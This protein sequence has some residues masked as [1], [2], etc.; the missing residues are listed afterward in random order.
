MNGWQRFA[1]LI[2]CCFVVMVLYPYFD[3]SGWTFMGVAFAMWTGVIMV[4]SVI[5]NLFGLYKFESLNKLIFF[6]LICAIMYSLLWYFPQEDKVTPINKIKYGEIPTK[7]DMDGVGLSNYKVVKPGQIAYVPDTSRRGDKISLGFND[8]KETFLVSS[9]STVFG[10]KRKFL[11]PEHLMLFLTRK[12]N[13]EEKSWHFTTFPLEDKGVVEGFLCIENSRRHPTSAALFSTLIPY[14]LHE[15]SRFA[16]EDK[17]V[18]TVEQLMG[19]PDLRSYMNTIYSLNSDKYSTLGAIC[20]DIPSMP[21][22]NNSQGFEY[23]SKLLWY[24]S[25][26]LTD[27]FGPAL[28]FR[29][30]EAEFIAFCPNTTKDVFSGKCM[31]AVSNLQR[32]Y[33]QDVRIGSSWADGTFSGR[34]LVD[35]ARENM[36][37]E[38]VGPY[39]TTA[40]IKAMEGLFTDVEKLNFPSLSSTISRR[41]I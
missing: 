15:R 6:V 5:S 40:G 24:V 21:A 26:T 14:M 27:I 10:T 38:K 31:R 41:S 19:L 39:P 35:E 11:L 18:K 33:P 25:K 22:I 12:E 30:W 8:T 17:G 29:T 3:A 9:I 7:A 13:G 16:Q 34:K 2:L 36:H 32:R 4:L 1:V 37:M 23:G 20:I 28:L